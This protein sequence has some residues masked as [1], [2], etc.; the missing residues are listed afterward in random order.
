MKRYEYE[1]EGGR[2]PLFDLVEMVFGR[3]EELIE[4]L[5]P[6]MGDERSALALYKL[7]DAFY[8]ANQLNLA[9]TYL[10][11]VERMDRIMNCFKTAIETPPEG[12]LSMLAHDPETIKAMNKTPQW[13]L[14]SVMA[15][16]VYRNFQKY[17]NPDMVEEKHK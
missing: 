16:F 12:E 1:L 13:K 6:S 15:H 14:R 5:L 11:S 17:G 3:V 4:L 8:R 7:A 2:Q 10:N 9:P